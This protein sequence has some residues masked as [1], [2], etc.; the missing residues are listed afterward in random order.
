ME[1]NDFSYFGRGLLGNI[2]MKFESQCH[3]DLGGDSIESNLFTFF[4]FLA[5]AAIFIA[6]EPFKLFLVQGHLSNIPMKFE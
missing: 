6:A 5:L 3:K 2:P 4:Q 1:R